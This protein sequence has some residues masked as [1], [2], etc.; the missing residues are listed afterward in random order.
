MPWVSI[1]VLLPLLGALSM[2][3]VPAAPAGLRQARIHA[4]ATAGGTV[5]FTAILIGLFDQSAPNLQY[6]DHVGWAEQVGL[7]WDVGVDGISL[8]L[9]ALT[10]GT[11]LL[12]V[13][14]ACWR[15]PERP[16]AFL[17]LLLLAEVGLIGLFA[18]GNLVLFYVF[19]EA[20]L[21]PFYFLIGMWG[22]A[23]RARA[24]IT[25]VI[26]TMVGSLLMLVAILAT[27]FVARDITGQFTFQI[28]DLAGVAFTDTQSTWLFLG[29]A[30]AFVI[31]LPLWPFH[32]WLPG[33][34]RAAPILVTGLL[35]A[36][37]SKAGA[38]GLLRIG[39]PVFPEGA[40]RFAIPI[41]VLAVAG[42]VYGSLVAWRQPTMRGL[43]AYSSVAHLG[44]IALG[45]VAFDVQAS[46]GAVLQMVNHG[47]VVLATFA[48]VG[49]LNRSA[50]DDR[51]DEIGGLAD[52]APRMAGVFLLVT[53]AA[54]AIPGANTFVGE[55]FILTGVFRHNVWL[56]VLACIG[57]AYAA[58]YM[59][60]LY[61]R[62]MNGPPRGDARAVELRAGD[63]MLL[64]PLVAAML[65]IALWPKA[66]VD[67]TTPAIEQNIAP[68]QV[69]ADRPADQIA[70]D[71]PANPPAD[72]KPL[73]GDDDEAEAAAGAG[74]GTGTG[75]GAP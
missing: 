69:A 41:G 7:A 53:M 58:V 16:R 55:F 5:V 56:A 25:F 34:Y 23:G 15:P 4:I 70:G 46:Q 6:I 50:T 52:G 35:A 72:A 68:A 45:I 71:I 9:L 48:I 32:G 28:R 61:Q 33:V 39:L 8:W 37:M 19:W 62:T 24:N 17:A 43:V 38:Y 21:V 60:R 31:K 14:G 40:D 13:L 36:V 42:I 67:A 57:I 30:L 10:A 66:L 29:F 11:F 74:T 63:L 49:M 3:A 44:F 22:G 2:L 18:A 26:Y 12:A 1:I 59:L 47:I 75:T 73:P 27:A 64:V 54:L 51:I 65:F 20:M